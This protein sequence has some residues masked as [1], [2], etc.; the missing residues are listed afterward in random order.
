METQ[1]CVKLRRDKASKFVEE[2]HRESV[3]WSVRTDA[4]RLRAGGPVFIEEY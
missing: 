1:N 2:K 4:A 3:S